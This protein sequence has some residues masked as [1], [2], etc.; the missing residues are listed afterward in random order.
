MLIRTPA[1][2]SGQWRSIPRLLLGA[3]VVTLA[4]SVGAAAAI[5][6]SGEPDA[7][8][9]WHSD[10]EVEVRTGDL[11]FRR[12]LGFTSQAVLRTDPEALYSHVGIAIRRGEDVDVVHAVPFNYL[13]GFTLREPLRDFLAPANATAGAV[14]RLRHDL[15]PRVELLTSVLTGHVDRRTRFDDRFD[16]DDDNKLYCTELVWKALRSV[17]ID[18]FPTLPAPRATPLGTRSFL[19]PA[20]LTRHP[21]IVPIIQF[22]A[23][24]AARA[25]LPKRLD[26]FYFPTI[27]NVT[28]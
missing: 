4:A 19:L 27:R 2:R 6:A 10:L 8:P 12:G 9:L 5:S 23:P 26:R 18:L 3:A 20:D 28:R 14:Y 15:A 17:G 21:E 13:D 24:A 16:L 22:A 11:I 1:A 7:S 25:R